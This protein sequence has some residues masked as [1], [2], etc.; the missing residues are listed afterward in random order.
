MLSAF[1]AAIHF[2]ISYKYVKI[3]GERNKY[4]KPL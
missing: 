4:K 3:R 1:R 2:Q